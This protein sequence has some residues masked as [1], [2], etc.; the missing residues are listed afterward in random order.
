[1]TKIQNENSNMENGRRAGG[2]SEGGRGD[3]LTEKWHLAT[4]ADGWNIIRRQR[5]EVGEGKHDDGNSHKFKHRTL[6]IVICVGS[7]STQFIFCANCIQNNSARGHTTH[8]QSMALRYISIP[9]RPRFDF[10]TNAQSNRS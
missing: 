10:R 3:L 2:E 5:V 1:M 9:V 6:L 8:T 4:N 7:L